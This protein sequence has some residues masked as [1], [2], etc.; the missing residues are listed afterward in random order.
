MTSHL[1]LGQE[2][3]CFYS[4]TRPRGEM[5]G[6]RSDYHRLCRSKESLTVLPTTTW[7][8]LGW[9]LEC[10]VANTETEQPTS[11]RWADS[12]SQRIPRPALCPQRSWVEPCGQGRLYGRGL[13]CALH[14][15]DHK[16]LST[17]RISSEL[18]S[19]KPRLF[20]VV[21]LRQRATGRTIAKGQLHPKKYCRTPRERVT[22]KRTDPVKCGR[23]YWCSH[24]WVDIEVTKS[25]FVGGPISC[26]QR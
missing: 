19:Q 14:Q 2:N 15:P 12:C 16:I 9:T 7:L 24:L 23:F 1:L 17:V 21:I 22:P 13:T 25:I 4:I 6:A 18:Q 11:G 5:L 26:D 8:S 20:Y 10:T 3:I